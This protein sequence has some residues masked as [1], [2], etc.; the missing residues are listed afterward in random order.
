LKRRRGHE[1]IALDVFTVA[2]AKEG[3]QTAPLLVSGRDGA[4]GRRSAQR[5]LCY[6][7]ELN[8]SAQARWLKTIEVF[9]EEG[10]SRQLKLF[11]SEVEPPLEEAGVARVQLNGVRLER[12]RRF[13]ECWVGLELWRRPGLEGFFEARLDSEEMTE[14]AWSRVGAVLAINRLGR[15][16]IEL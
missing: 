7:G 8:G 9:N 16:N 3:R 4:N 13:G 10:E 5:T 11:P 1:T 6:L 12:G 15:S 14:V 2:R